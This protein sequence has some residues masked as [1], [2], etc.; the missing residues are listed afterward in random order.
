M[1]KLV[2]SN[3]N[4]AQ[5]RCLFDEGGGFFYETGLCCTNIIRNFA[6][7]ELI[8]WLKWHE[9]IWKFKASFMHYDRLHVCVGHLV[10]AT[11]ILY[12]L[13]RLRDHRLVGRI[14]REDGIRVQRFCCRLDVV[15]TVSTS[16]ADRHDFFLFIRDNSLWCSQ[17]WS[18]RLETRAPL[19]TPC[20]S[21]TNNWKWSIRSLETIHGW[22][23]RANL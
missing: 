19:S 16:R 5:E 20:V 3:S 13:P 18:L 17:C 8:L 12:A 23:W 6:D 1:R 2:W 4:V 15:D 22:V 14:L 11:N 9:F 21:P 7:F 10:A